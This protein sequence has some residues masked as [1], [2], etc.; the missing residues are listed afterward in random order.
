MAV[1]SVGG[2]NNT[3]NKLAVL[4][5]YG[6]TIPNGIGWNTKQ[7]NFSI[8]FDIKVLRF[9]MWFWFGKFFIQK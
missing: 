4:K 8:R 5:A 7:Y 3:V 2:I 6:F 9:K 1:I